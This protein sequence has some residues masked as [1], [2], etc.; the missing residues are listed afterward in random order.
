MRR[1]GR[2]VAGVGPVLPAAAEAEPEVVRGGDG[3]RRGDGG[4]PL[5]R[6]AAAEH[7]GLP[8]LPGGVPDHQE[9]L[10]AV[11]H[12]AHQPWLLLSGA[13]VLLCCCVLFVG[14]WLDSV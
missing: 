10:P 5:P 13:G 3:H 14:H 8:P 11:S 4:L 7:S 12:R 1:D 2:R 6:A 9:V